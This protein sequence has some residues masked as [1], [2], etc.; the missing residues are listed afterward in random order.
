MIKLMTN[1]STRILLRLGGLILL[2]T[3]CGES[4]T[5]AV[6]RDASVEDASQLVVE[7]GFPDSGDTTSDAGSQDAVFSLEPCTEAYYSELARQGP[8]QGSVVVFVRDLIRRPIEGARIVVRR[9][10]LEWFATSDSCGR[11][12]LSDPEIV[13]PLAIDVYAEGMVHRTRND[14]NDRVQQFLVYDAAGEWQRLSPPFAT[15]QGTVEGLE[16]IS[17]APGEAVYAQAWQMLPAEGSRLRQDTRGG[18]DVPANM[19]ILG[20]GFD[21]RDFSLKVDTGFTTPL[22]ALGGIVRFEGQRRQTQ[23]MMLGIGSKPLLRP[24]DSLQ[25]EQIRLDIP[26]DQEF[27]VTGLSPLFPD[28]TIVSRPSLELPDG[29]SISLGA[30]VTTTQTISVRYPS[31]TGPLAGAKVRLRIDNENR[32]SLWLA[33]WELEGDLTG[34]LNIGGFWEELRNSDFDNR[35]RAITIAQNDR[36]FFVDRCQLSLIDP[37][38]RRTVWVVEHFL[39]MDAFVRMPV[40]PEGVVDPLS[41]TIWT[42]VICSTVSLNQTTDLRARATIRGRSQ[43]IF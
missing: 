2:L 3:A 18:G 4:Q 11:A 13:G 38:T 32:Q 26:L 1:G 39:V 27:R 22:Y 14:T 12:E 17:P 7:A 37:N 24:D 20:G 29:S 19:M 5:D 35:G 21:L 10:T 6:T 23:A 33:I 41:G 31:L 43:F 36:T 25:G 15:V 28:N 8:I 34:D 9:D 30:V 42:D 40:P 16:A